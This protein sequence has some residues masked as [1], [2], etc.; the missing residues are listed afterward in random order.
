MVRFTQHPTIVFFS[1]ILGLVAFIG[2][3]II[4]YIQ[5]GFSATWLLVT[6]IAIAFSSTLYL[7]FNKQNKHM[8]F[9]LKSLAN[10]DSSLGLSQH[11]PMRQ[12]LEEIKTRIQSARFIA[13]QQAHF[14]QT[15]LVHIDLAVLVFDKDGNVIESNPAVTR[16]LGK[17][18]N[19]SQDLAHI[20]PL[21]NE[22]D[23]SV[24]T[25]ANW[26]HGEQQD[27]LSI[28]ITSAQI[29]GQI[30]KIVTLQSIRDALQNKE[31]QA[32][33]RLTKVLT[34]EVANSITPLSSIAQ[35]CEG[36][37]PDTLS[38]DDEEDKQDLALALQTL[39]KRTE[40]L[41]A[42]IARFRKVSNLPSP[43]LQPA[44]LASIVEGIYQLHQQTCHQANIDL[45]L[46]ISHSQLVMLDTAQI[47]QVLINLTKNAIEAVQLRNDP[48]QRNTRQVV[49]KTG[50]NNAGQHYVEI[51]DNGPGIAEHVIDMI[52]VPFFTTKQQG[53]GIGLSLS[54]QIM[55]NHGGDL[56][57]LRRE[58]GACFR[59]VFG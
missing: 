39:A 16:L 8:T 19:H 47:E 43:V 7:Q 29:Q 52:F 30:R 58:Q 35:T 44:Q 55:I 13:E 25:I 33:K 56:I 24:K 37:L 20:T 23:N 18:I 32:Y 28:Q 59:C 15:L 17:T 27:N 41:G 36:L 22:C 38:F 45:Q 2:L 10:G 48:D 11:H 53:S 49:L 5:G 42:F 40:Y 46:D 4:L 34:H 54:R 21:I 51:S 14:L 3:S 57:Y 1:T 31:Q 50:A 26:Q 12:H 6:L 9:V